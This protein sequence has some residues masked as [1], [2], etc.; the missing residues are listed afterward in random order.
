MAEPVSLHE[1]L[2]HLTEQDQGNDDRGRLEVHRDMPG[3]VRNELG[4]TTGATVPT[5]L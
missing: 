4:K 1:E 5:T 3:R 2:E